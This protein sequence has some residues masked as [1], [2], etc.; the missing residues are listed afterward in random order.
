MSEAPDVQ[1]VEEPTCAVARTLVEQWRAEAP[2]GML[3]R[4]LLIDRL[5]DLR[6][7]VGDAP[8][9]LLEIDRMLTWMPGATVVESRWWIEQLGLLDDMLVRHRPRTAV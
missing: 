1:L 9:L 7:A 5:L 2:T 3:R 8:L 4:S 6:L